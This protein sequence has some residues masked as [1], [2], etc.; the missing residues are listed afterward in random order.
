MAYGP[1]WIEMAGLPC[2]VVGGG[3]VAARKIAAL[4]EAGARVSVIGRELHPGLEALAEAGELRYLGAEYTDR[5]LDGVSLVFAATSDP[6]LN[7]RVAENARARGV[8]VN[9]VDRPEEGTFLVPATVRRGDLVIGVSTGG[10][11]P[12]LA[13]RVRERL[14]AEFGPEYA[15]FLDVMGRIR[16][17]L[18]AAGRGRAGNREQFR[19][20]V[21]SPL[22]EAI[23][24]KD[25]AAADAAIRDVL[26]EP[27]NL[28]DLGVRLDA[29]AS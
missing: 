14:E 27:M 20:L 13:A 19:G 29:E 15:V 22:L 26:G 21:D 8:W 3:A 24:G 16:E 25:A 10:R 23:R 12:A 9:V 1:L 11:S 28:S 4:R 5:S 18:L 2:L 17:R 6:D 7:R